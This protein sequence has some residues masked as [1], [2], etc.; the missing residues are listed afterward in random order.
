MQPGLLPDRLLVIRNGVDP[1]GP[2]RRHLESG[3]GEFA[4]VRRTVLRHRIKTLLPG[5]LRNRVI[6]ARTCMSILW[7]ATL[8]MTMSDFGDLIIDSDELRRWA[9]R[10]G[11]RPS[12]RRFVIV[13]GQ[14][15]PPEF[16]RLMRTLDVRL[17]IL[18]DS[19]DVPGDQG[20][21]IND[22]ALL[23]GAEPE[24]TD[25]LPETAPSV[26][27]FASAAGD[28]DLH[29]APRPGAGEPALELRAHPSFKAE[30]EFIADLARGEP[31]RSMGILVPTKSMVADYRDALRSAGIK[32]KWYL[33]GSSDNAPGINWRQPDKVVLTWSSA[34]GLK[35]DTVILPG[36]ETFSD[37]PPFG[38][39]RPRL[40][41]LSRIARHDLVI[42]YS[43]EGRPTV[44]DGV[45]D[46]HP[47]V[48][49]P[50][51]TADADSSQETPPSQSLPP[52]QDRRRATADDIA[53]ARELLSGD[54]RRTATKRRDLILTAEQEIG[55]AAL[56]R[57]SDLPLGTSLVQGYRA[58]LPSD[59]E[60]TRAFDAMLLH[61]QRLVFKI[62]RQFPADTLTLEDLHQEGNLGL[63]RAVEKFDATVGTKF[64]TYAT[65]WIKQA[66]SRALAD[67]DRLIRIP[68]HQ[69][70][71]VQRVLAARRRAE[72]DGLEPAPRELAA[73]TGYDI[74]T[75]V[76]CL[77]LG[78]GVLRLDAPL[79]VDG[80]ANGNSTLGDFVAA[81]LAAPEGAIESMLFGL[82]L[83]QALDSLPAR[84]A[85]I[86]RLRGGVG[87]GEPLS[88]DAVG[89]QMGLTR[90][91]IR[92]IQKKATGHL[93]DALSGSRPK[94]ALPAPRGV[95]RQRK[96]DDLDPF[97]SGHPRTQDMGTDVLPCGNGSI[98]VTPWVLPHPSLLSPDEFRAA[99]GSGARFE[100]Q[101]LYVRH[102]GRFLV[103][104][105]W[106]GLPGLDSD[107]ETS[108]ARVLV[109]LSEETLPLW[110]TEDTDQLTP[111]DDVRVRLTQLGRNAQE[112][113][114]QV[115]R[116]YGSPES[117]TP[118]SDR[119]PPEGDRHD[120]T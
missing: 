64:S 84:E 94:D 24:P 108:Q 4:I 83:H 17:T 6:G 82:D 31:A 34:L 118:G 86:L 55:L 76:Y 28:T 103:R 115:H 120:S 104:G 68:V 111:P 90:E 109:E 35:F 52:G 57:G 48:S 59:D 1:V 100:R 18:A 26:D 67:K 25:D 42:S 71:K 12:P 11:R 70:E 30:V 119:L 114:R 5:N 33:S 116:K 13:N 63:I 21:S 47:A 32:V 112:R 62:A 73:R 89:E 105:G 51:V 49:E 72:A 60:R 3:D 80:D 43:G 7:Q 85:S 45:P 93:R 2:V 50:D 101:G 79:T 95:P 20:T 75:V 23:T 53:A 56:I 78:A 65:W 29:A 107:S 19:L 41:A 106:L 8:S 88:L 69:L 44:M 87:T 91:R 38:R 46:T 37:E 9:V 54:L 10:H 39:I 96:P 36:L 102:A 113:A 14:Q 66:I 40:A 117:G 110:R 16:Y 15:F 58:N 77:R 74:P 99:G 97:L 98:E 92:Q 27:A 22:M 61:N 81:G